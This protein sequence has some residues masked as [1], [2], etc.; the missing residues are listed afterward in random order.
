MSLIIK[1]MMCNNEPNNVV[2]TVKDSLQ[3][4]EYI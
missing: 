4:S 2:I 3:S 1:L